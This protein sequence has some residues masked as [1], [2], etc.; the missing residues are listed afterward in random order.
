ME[1]AQ[2]MGV[3]GLHL[4]KPNYR[5]TGLRGG[6]VSAHSRYLNGHRPGNE[7][8]QN[9]YFILPVNRH[10]ND[11]NDR[12]FPKCPRIWDNKLVGGLKATCS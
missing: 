5:T 6:V 12:D 2:E 8:T 7:G 10:V 9:V 4:E 3:L 1:E 11:L